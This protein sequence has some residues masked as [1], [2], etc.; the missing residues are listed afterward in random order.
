MRLGHPQI[1]VRH[2]GGEGALLHDHRRRGGPPPA[3]DQHLAAPDPDDRPNRAG[4]R[5]DHL[6]GRQIL[7]RAFPARRQNTGRGV[8][9]PPEPVLGRAKPDLWADH[10]TGEKSCIPTPYPDAYGVKPDHDGYGAPYPRAASATPVSV[11][12]SARICRGPKASPSSNV[13]PITP[14]IGDTSTVVAA[15]DAGTSFSARNHAR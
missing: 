3:R 15:V 9:G 12:A 14:I 5:R 8:G 4:Q 7:N 2:V 13:D 10:D 11:I 6:A 1:G